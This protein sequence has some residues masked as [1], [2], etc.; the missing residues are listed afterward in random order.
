MNKLSILVYAA[1][2]LHAE[3]TLDLIEA[4]HF[5]RA[6]PGVEARL[7]ANP[8]DAQANYEMG[9][10][11]RAFGDTDAALEYAKK[12]VDLDGTKAPYHAFLGEALADAA[13]H[14]GMFKAMGMIKGI[15]KELDTALA[16]D[17]KNIEAITVYM[18]FYFNAPAI[19]GGDKGK[20]R[21]MADDA[22][23]ANAA[24]GY[25][26]KVRLAN[27][28]KATD[29]VEGLIR[30]AVESDAK[31]YGA[32]ISL[33]NYL[34]NKQQF[35]EA[36]KHAREALRLD[37]GRVGAYASLA[38]IYAGQKKWSELDSILQDGVKNVPDDLGPYYRA[39]R[40]LLAN[41]ADLPRAESYFRKYLSQEPEGNEPQHP[42][43]HWSLGLV[44]EKMGRK[45]DAAAEIAQCVQAKP[46]FEP[47]KKDLA[48]LKQ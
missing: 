38:A 23:K 24:R 1:A 17:P 5:K 11:K 41:G 3:S 40:T 25:L 46:Q 32:R 27:E 16:I 7:K 31:L 33:A 47:A 9:R 4:N 43:A 8:N 13:Q 44:F 12:A 45:S 39:G 19:A 42:F 37:P 28:E 26:V 48:R 6:R 29:Q 30:K 36:E 18:E 20:A 34:A 14:A 2:A 21:T 10:I 22:V 35:D 15:R